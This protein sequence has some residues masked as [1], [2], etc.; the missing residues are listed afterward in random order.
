MSADAPRVEFPDDFFDASEARPE[1][2]PDNP[3]LR[4]AVDWLRSFMPEAEWKRRR[5]AAARRLYDAA[6]GQ[7]EDPKGRFFNEADT[8]AWHLFQAEAYLDHIQ[9]Y[10]PMYGSRVVP[11]MIALGKNLPALLGVGGV[12]RCVRRMVGSER[13]QPNGGM[14]ELLVAA[15]YTREGFEVRFVEEQRGGSK[16]HDM[17][18]RRRDR[19]WAVEC[20]RLEVSEYGGRERI[21]MRELWGPLGQS[22]ADMGRSIFADVNFRVEISSV[23]YEYLQGHMIRF[24]KSGMQPLQWDDN[25]STG[26]VRQL[27]LSPLKSLLSTDVVLGSGTQILRL[28]SGE[29]VRN[30][31]YISLL[32]AKPSSNPRWIDSCDLAIL[33][34]WELSSAEAISAKA[35]DITKRLAEANDQVPADRPSIVHIGFEAVDGD[36]VEQARYQKILETTRR[37]DPAGKNLQYVYCHYL[38]PES[39]PDEAW[40]F[41][42]TVQCCPIRPTQERPLASAF[43]APYGGQPRIGVHWQP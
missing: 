41:D 7:V 28:L 5:L 25:L 42:E 27:D 30:A 43:L 26:F 35:R 17:D 8:F 38:V 21:R 15:A 13:S 40:A 36:V 2:W 32:N 20:K 23:A 1:T 37:F 31:S 9:N 19:E 12:E 33:L 24:A 18:V 4:Q 14:F 29:Y 16:T 22:F 3:D 10:E 39:P 6:L 34:H 11:L